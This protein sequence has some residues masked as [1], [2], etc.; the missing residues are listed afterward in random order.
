MSL[1]LL[2][3]NKRDTFEGDGEISSDSSHTFEEHKWKTSLQT[4]FRNLIEH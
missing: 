2:D 1:S 3:F 4:S